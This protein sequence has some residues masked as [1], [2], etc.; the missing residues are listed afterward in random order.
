MKAEGQG[1]LLTRGAEGGACRQGVHVE[2]GCLGVKNYED[3]TEAWQCQ[4]HSCL[5]VKEKLA[6]L[7][8]WLKRFYALGKFVVARKFM[9]YVRESQC[10]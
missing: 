4:H 5:D 6:C 10:G 1:T 7:D 2:W 3:V 9:V 8:L